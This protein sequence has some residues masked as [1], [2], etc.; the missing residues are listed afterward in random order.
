M[1]PRKHDHSEQ[2]LCDDFRCLHSVVFAV[3]VEYGEGV[4]SV[5]QMLGA[6]QSLNQVLKVNMVR[7]SGYVLRMSAERSPHCML[8]REA[9][10]G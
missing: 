6:R 1:R 2:N 3:V 9:G 10:N 5:T 7:W 8:F 4:V